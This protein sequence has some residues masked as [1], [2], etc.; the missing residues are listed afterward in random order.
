MMI[1]RSWRSILEPDAHTCG[2]PINGKKLED[3]LPLRLTT[4]CRLDR[5]GL[6]VNFQRVPLGGIPFLFA[7][8]LISL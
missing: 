4:D 1:T 5:H 6:E 8:Y 3:A 2:D 7:D